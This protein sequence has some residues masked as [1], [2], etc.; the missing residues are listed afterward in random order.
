MFV[1]RV[2]FRASIFFVGL[3]SLGCRQPSV[4]DYVPDDAAARAALT[5]ALDAWK[6]GNRPDQIGASDP[7]VQA[8]DIQWRDGQK[9]VAYEVVGTASAPTDDPNRRYTVKLTL[10]GA[11]APQETVYTP[12]KIPS[13]CSAK[14][15]ISS[16]RAFNLAATQKRV[17][18]R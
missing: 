14:P 9:L 15:A 8:Q 18:G 6:E 10:A 13:S 5:T 11:T 7:A 4:K 17:A 3:L 1:N 16:S 2:S 12:S